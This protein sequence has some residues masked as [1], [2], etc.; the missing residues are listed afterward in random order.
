MK[1]VYNR[2]FSSGF[3]LGIPVDEWTER[4][5]SSA[6]TTKIH[7]GIVKKYYNKIGVA[8]IQVQSNPFSTDDTIMF[9]GPATGVVIQKAGSIEIDHVNITMAE[10]GSMIAVKTESRVRPN[11]R[12]FVVRENV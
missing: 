9:Q 10:K 3:F 5:G 4:Y 1:K 2:E 11:D 7:V 12:V 6:T 8:E